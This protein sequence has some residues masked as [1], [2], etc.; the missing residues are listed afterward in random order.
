MFFKNQATFSAKVLII[1]VRDRVRSNEPEPQPTLMLAAASRWPQLDGWRER[2]QNISRYILHVS[3]HATS[4][5]DSAGAFESGMP[6]C[7][8]WRPIARYPV[9]FLRGG[10]VGAKTK[11]NS[12]IVRERTQFA[13]VAAFPQR[14][15]D[16]A[17]G[18]RNRNEGR[19]TNV[20]GFDAAERAQSGSHCADRGRDLLADAGARDRRDDL[21]LSRPRTREKR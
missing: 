1:L 13:R 12:K 5:F 19:V 4:C 14:V 21:P 15:V 8:A 16:E 6:L 9:S 20:D 3:H 2:P 18:T 10:P 11:P 7:G 17:I